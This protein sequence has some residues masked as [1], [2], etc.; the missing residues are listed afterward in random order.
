MLDGAA[1]H[2]VLPDEVLARPDEAVERLINIEAK[3]DIFTGRQDA[4]FEEMRERLAHAE[5]RLDDLLRRLPQPPA[6]PVAFLHVPKCAGT[7]FT[8][9]LIEAAAPRCAV[10][11]F[12]RC[13]FG[14]FEDFGGFAPAQRRDVYFGPRQ[15]SPFCDMLAGHFSLTTIRAW[16]PD[17]AVVMLLREP[18]SRLLS[19]W[20]FWRA[21]AA[22]AARTLGRW[23]EVVARA[24]G[25]FADFLTAPAAAC[26]TDNVALRM[27]LWPHALIPADDF[28]QAA[29]DEALLAQA[30]RRLAGLACVNV[31]ENPALEQD[32][33]AWLRR[34]FAMRRLKVTQGVPPALR[35]DLAAELSQAARRL[36]QARTR[37]DRRLWESA[38]RRVMPG[39]DVA[40]LGA[41]ALAESQARHG[42][43]LA[44]G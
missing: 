2:P 20:V 35:A 16:A 34:D 6:R 30:D 40:A 24:L 15:I 19:H 10:G 8:A 36:W 4:R 41:A 3:L 29:H 12:D 31:V 42:C 1:S 37:L 39:Q 27:L 9:S 18:L 38:C 26:Q 23:H 28:I 33:A 25:S 13:L 14:A 21:E 43:L 17:A 11:G 5:E 7:S 44:G 22:A 32:M